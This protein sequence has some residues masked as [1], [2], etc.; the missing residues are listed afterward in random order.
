MTLY[1]PRMPRW[2]H[3][4]TWPDRAAIDRVVLCDGVKVARVYQQAQGPQKGQWAWFGQWDGREAGTA[5]TLE[6]AL[7]VVRERWSDIHDPKQ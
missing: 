6:E 4:P 7:S 1:P 2:T 3:R 5:A